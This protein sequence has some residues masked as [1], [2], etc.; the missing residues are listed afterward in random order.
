MTFPELRKKEGRISGLVALE[1]AISRKKRGKIKEFLLLTAP[2]FVMVLFFFEENHFIPFE[3]L[4][5]LMFLIVSAWLVIF[6][7]DAFYYSH[8]FKGA[9]TLLSEWGLRSNSDSITYEV[10]EIVSHTHAA[11]FT[12]GFLESNAGR[13]ITVRLDIPDQE[14]DTFINS[15]RHTVYADPI[16]IS[17][18]VTL[19]SYA[20]KVYEADHDFAQFLERRGLSKQDLLSV[21]SWVATIYERKKEIHRW[22]GRD[23]L[24][25]IRGIGKDWSKPETFLLEKY[26]TFVMPVS[27]EVLFRKE[28]DELEKA[29]TRSPSGSV[30]MVAE[31]KNE[32]IAIVSGLAGRIRDGSV[33]PRLEHKKIVTLNTWTLTEEEPTDGRFE[34]LMIRLFNEAVAA[35]N[36]ILVIPDLEALI[37][38][39]KKHNIY[40]EEFLEPYIAS[41]NLNIVACLS[42]DFYHSIARSHPELDHHFEKVFIEHEE[43][44]VLVQALEHKVFDIERATHMLFT[45]QA[46]VTFARQSIEKFG[47]AEKNI[48]DDLEDRVLKDFDAL[49]AQLVKKKV[50][51]VTVAHVDGRM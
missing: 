26:G 10:V 35:E 24:G 29:L 25:R 16:T 39:A 46:L 13:L 31:A 3:I 44:T 49:V 7:I 23:S 30:M 48:P 42:N 18:P 21:A 4:Y 36:I 11:D 41:P 17:D 47:K 9:K 43:K 37:L 15:N 19:V 8:Y 50:A 45:Y 5:G 38:S 14:V 51:K 34:A 22:W 1:R 28:I 27:D 20:R 33:L 32:H 12:K 6:M 40:F 2:I